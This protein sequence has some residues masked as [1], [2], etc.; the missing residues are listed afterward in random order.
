MWLIIHTLYPLHTLPIITHHMQT[1]IYMYMCIYTVQPLIGGIN[2]QFLWPSNENCLVLMWHY[3]E[4]VLCSGMYIYNFSVWRVHQP[5]TELLLGSSPTFPACEGSKVTF[6]K[7][8]VHVEDSLVMWQH[9]VVWRGYHMTV[10]MRATRINGKREEKG[11]F[12]LA[13]LKYGNETSQCVSICRH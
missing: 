5:M 2:N 6:L 7:N 8:C 1:Y 10:A 4:V 11:L 13:C 3:F 12:W 9:V